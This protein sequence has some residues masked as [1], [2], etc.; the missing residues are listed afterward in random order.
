LFIEETHGSEV[1][2]A[3]RR[4]LGG[5]L[6]E[7]ESHKQPRIVEGHLMPDHIHLCMGIPPKYAVSKRQNANTDFPTRC[8]VNC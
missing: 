3:V 8:D 6:H 4:H 7:L 5:M 1:F 2:G